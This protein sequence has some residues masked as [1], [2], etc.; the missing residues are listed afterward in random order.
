MKVCPDCGG[1]TKVT[2]FEDEDVEGMLQTRSVVSCERCD[3]HLYDQQDGFDE[4][5]ELED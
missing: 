3:W 4:Y 1:E 2:N 5:L